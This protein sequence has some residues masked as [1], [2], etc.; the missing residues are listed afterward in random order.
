MTS[1]PV[2]PAALWCLI[3][4]PQAS[5]F[6]EDAILACATPDQ[7]LTGSRSLV[8][9]RAEIA[10]ELTGQV[11]KRAELVQ[12]VNTGRDVFAEGRLLDAAGAPTLTFACRLDLNAGWKDHAR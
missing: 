7:D 10:K 8:R 11:D 12:A 2:V 5:L 9:G 4:A 3:E 6:T 1:S